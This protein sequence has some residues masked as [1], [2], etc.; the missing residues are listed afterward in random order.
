MIN[1]FRLRLIVY[2]YEYSTSVRNKNCTPERQQHR[3]YG[4]FA[5]FSRLALPTLWHWARL[6]PLRPLS[7]TLTCSSCEGS[8][9]NRDHVQLTGY[10]WYPLAANCEQGHDDQQGFICFGISHDHFLS[11]WFHLR[12]V[13]LWSS[14]YAFLNNQQIAAGF[15]F[16]HC[17]VHGRA[18]ALCAKM[19]Q[20]K[21][22]SPCSSNAHHR[23]LQSHTLVSTDTKN[24]DS[25]L[26]LSGACH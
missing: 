10:D 26:T 19:L 20:H 7:Q 24:F 5:W 16:S 8:K 11:D 23:Y 2:I 4:V 3:P 9:C 17:L 6:G 14:P 25:N 18:R 21:G 12:R 22:N 1:R 13:Q 15:S